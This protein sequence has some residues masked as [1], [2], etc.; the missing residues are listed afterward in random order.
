MTIAI[1]LVCT[2][3]VVLGTDLQYTGSYEKFPGKKLWQL[4]P[5]RQG[6][7][8]LTGAGNPTSIDHVKRIAETEIRKGSGSTEDVIYALEA[9]LR[10]LYSLHIDV[11]PKESQ[12]AMEVWIMLAMRDGSGFR[13][14]HNDRSV[15][16]G[17]ERINCSGL[18]LYVGYTMLDL[19]LPKYCTVDLAAQIV[20]YVL[21]HSKEWSQDVGKG[22]NVH[23]LYDSGHW[24]SLLNRP[25]FTGG[26]LI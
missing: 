25:G 14:F 11:A 16:A 18:G 19:L 10:S 20:A 22:S 1:G 24:E 9:G 8:I 26:V 5:E 17:V 3:G 13:L 6:T 4:C 21:A 15:L 7:I 23:L 12:S 2:D